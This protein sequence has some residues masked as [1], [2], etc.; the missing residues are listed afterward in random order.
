MS[1]TVEFINKELTRIIEYA[2]EHKFGIDDLS[3]IFSAMQLILY[4]EFISLDERMA[5]IFAGRM[6]QTANN[7]ESLYKEIMKQ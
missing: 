3:G 5:D 6:K 1:E 7:L 4:K 2:A